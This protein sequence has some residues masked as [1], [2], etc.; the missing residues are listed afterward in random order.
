MLQH[1]SCIGQP[2]L[3]HLCASFIQLEQ[4]TAAMN[5]WLSRPESEKLHCALVTA[6]YIAHMM[7]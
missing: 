7:Q 6:L 3:P 4:M 1:T 5:Y 2:G